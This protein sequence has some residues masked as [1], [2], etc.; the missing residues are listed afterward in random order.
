MHSFI[1]FQIFISSIIGKYSKYLILRRSLI[2]YWFNY[3]NTTN[4]FKSG[5]SSNSG[6]DQNLFF[7]A[8]LITNYYSTD[9]YFNV[10]WEYFFKYILTTI[11]FFSIDGV[12]LLVVPTD[13]HFEMY[14]WLL[15]YEYIKSGYNFN[16]GC[17]RE[18]MKYIKMKY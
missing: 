11:D 13:V 5:C 2:H 16:S 14:F 18:Q 3:F 7:N 1:I 9:C 4:R 6:W 15:F 17:N 12:I 10:A 8:F